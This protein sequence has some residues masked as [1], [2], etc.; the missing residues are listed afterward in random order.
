VELVD[1]IIIIAK[2]E[3]WRSSVFDVDNLSKKD[4]NKAQK[5]VGSQDED[6]GSLC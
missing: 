3:D 5:E 4:K 2:D 6:Q 1:E